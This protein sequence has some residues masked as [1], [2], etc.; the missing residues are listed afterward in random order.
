MGISRFIGLLV[1]LAVTARPCS[2][3]STRMVWAKKPGSTS[4]LFAFERDGKVGFINPRGRIVIQPSIAARID[5]VGD[6]SG[7]LAP[8]T[9]KGKRGFIDSAGTMVIPTLYDA[10]GGFSGGRQLS[11]LLNVVD[12]TDVRVVE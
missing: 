5:R 11:M 12:G 8:V 9:L 1:L 10:C 3:A 4:N 7:G 6:F 2:I